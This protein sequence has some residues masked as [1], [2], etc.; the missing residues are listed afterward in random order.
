MRFSDCVKCRDSPSPGT[1]NHCSLMLSGKLVVT[2]LASI[3]RAAVELVDRLAAVSC[4]W[5][6][7]R[8]PPAIGRRLPAFGATDD[9]LQPID[10]RRNWISG[11][12]RKGARGLRIVRTC[13]SDSSNPLWLEWLRSCPNVRQSFRS[14]PGTNRR[15]TSA[16]PQ[17]CLR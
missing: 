12:A 13:R 10:G 17:T 16:C 2:E 8:L 7:S 5:L 1:R 11:I 6:L 4:H 14:R 9:H 15:R 3:L